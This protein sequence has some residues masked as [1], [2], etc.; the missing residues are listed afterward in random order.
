MLAEA[1]CSRPVG[2]RL[3]LDLVRYDVARAQ[4]SSGVVGHERLGSYHAHATAVPA[5]R[6]N[7]PGG[8][9][10]AADR[11]HGDVR[12]IIEAGQFVA[13]RGVPRD[14]ERIVVGACDVGLGVLLRQLRHARR[15]LELRGIDQVH[16]AAIGQDRVDLH[17][18]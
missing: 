12:R 14:D 16:S 2:N 11:R 4:R 13:K 15:T 18:C 3:R 17:A 1:Q 9:S 5:R 8:Q 6:L 7:E 10:A